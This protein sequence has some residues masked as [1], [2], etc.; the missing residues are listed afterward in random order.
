MRNDIYNLIP[1]N[2]R[3]IIK[4]AEI[5]QERINMPEINSALEQYRKIPS[6]NFEE[7]KKLNQT[8]RAN[9]A[10][11]ELINKDSDFFSNLRTLQSSIQKIFPDGELLKRIE[12]WQINEEFIGK[13]T[14]EQTYE[15]TEDEPD[16]LISSDF[17]ERLIQVDNLP[18]KLINAIHNEPEL[19]RSI[20][21]R[22]FEFYI[23]SLLETLGFKQIEIT[24]SSNDHGRD[25]I[26]LQYVHGIPLLFAFEC[27]QYRKDRKIKPEILRA[28]IGTVHSSN[29]KANKGVLVTTSSFTSG[30]R[31]IFLSETSIAGKDFN[32][33]VEWI[34][35]T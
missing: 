10:F 34:K 9:P 33:I 29:T 18:V 22:Q 3:E 27:K 32:D 19:M 16:E 20:S 7:I 28:L 11:Y 30:C 23:A 14:T 26:A 12:S 15:E 17:K 25:I 2:F 6:N 4:Q 8:L 21:P 1:P 5:L 31:D 13:I 35:N 24:P